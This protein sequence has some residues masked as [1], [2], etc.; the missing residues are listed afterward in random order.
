M[1]QDGGTRLWH[2]QPLL[3]I[4]LKRTYEDTYEIFKNING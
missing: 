3:A 4:G 1:N 2:D